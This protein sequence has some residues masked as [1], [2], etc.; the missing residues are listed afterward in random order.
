MLINS[1][2]VY[3]GQHCMAGLGVFLSIQQD[4]LNLFILSHHTPVS[5]VTRCSESVGKHRPI[6]YKTL[7]STQ[8]N[9]F[10]R[11]LLKNCAKGEV[12][13][14]RWCNCR[15]T[16]DIEGRGQG[17]GLSKQQIIQSLSTC[18]LHILN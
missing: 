16:L 17:P 4:L 15:T 3:S 2:H 9:N 14:P 6:R 5:N 13:G 18:D 7:L 8:S 11:Q 10:S 1:E 12:W